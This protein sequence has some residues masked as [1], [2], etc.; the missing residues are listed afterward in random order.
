LIIAVVLLHV[1]AALAPPPYRHRV[2]LPDLDP[3]IAY[4]L[5]PVTTIGVLAL[6]FNI[7]CLRSVDASFFQ[8]SA[9]LFLRP[10]QN[11]PNLIV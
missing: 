7:L 1:L 9:L 4:K 2:A 5:L 11:K 8:A 3:G 6:A 10:K